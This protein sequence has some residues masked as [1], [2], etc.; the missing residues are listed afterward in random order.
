MNS[1][2]RRTRH[3]LTRLTVL[4]LGLL[5]SA[6]G[7][8]APALAATAT[9]SAEMSATVITECSISTASL[10]FGTYDP[11]SANKTAPLDASVL[12]TF[13]CTLG[14]DVTIRLGQ[15]LHA[16]GGSSDTVPLRRMSAGGTFLSY[17]L[18]TDSARTTVWGNTAETGIAPIT[19]GET[20][21]VEAF[22]RIPAGQNVPAGSYTDTVVVS[23]NF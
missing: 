21:D 22:G 3:S 5:V 23:V 12:I 17:F 7:P 8:A 2:L 13:V 10:D 18:Y 15:G 1:L 9:S 16:A 6:S 19:T 11:I 4:G 14:S 20:Q